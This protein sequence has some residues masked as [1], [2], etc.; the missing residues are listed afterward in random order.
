MPSLVFADGRAAVGAALVLGST[1]AGI[2]GGPL[3][4][5]LFAGAGLLLAGLM[6]PVALEPRNAL[7]IP[8]ALIAG[9]V[10]RWRWA[11]FV[12][13]AALIPLPEVGAAW[14]FGLLVG[15]AVANWPV[16]IGKPLLGVLAAST[17]LGGVMTVNAG[18]VRVT[19]TAPRA[20]LVVAGDRAE[21]LGS[22]QK[23]AWWTAG[24]PPIYQVAPGSLTFAALPDVPRVEALEPTAVDL[25]EVGRPDCATLA[26]Q[27]T[28]RDERA[29]VQYLL[30]ACG[31]HLDN[32]WSLHADA[33]RVLMGQAP[34]GDEADLLAAE[35]STPLSDP[36]AVLLVAKLRLGSTKPA[37]QLLVEGSPYDRAV[38]VS[39]MSDE[40]RDTTRSLIT[41]WADDVPQSVDGPY[42][43][44]LEALRER[45]GS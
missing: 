6:V 37:A 9:L 24:A 13:C 18:F 3:T 8:I 19:N 21:V 39:H 32:A 33:A 17:L 15:L 20:I 14:G 1:A 4:A 34:M 28:M 16:P 38:L 25:A 45:P 27:G 11:P 5:P 22:G 31:H 40:D 44:A 36:D 29:V 26:E 41:E 43:R 2:R 12:V 42:R 35:W 23:G 30:H 10:N 7:L